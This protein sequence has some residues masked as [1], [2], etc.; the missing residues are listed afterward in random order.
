M[1]EL[2]PEAFLSRVPPQNL[3]G[4]AWAENLPLP[5]VAGIL[6][7]CRAYLGNDSGITH[8]AAAVGT[9]MLAIF[10]PTDPD[11]WGPRGENVTIIRGRAP[12]SP[13]SRE[14]RLECENRQCVLSVNADRVWDQLQGAM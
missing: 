4:G 5:T 13:C 14:K 11:V 12:C 1:K 10:G 7:K 2:L 8:I 3:F 6:S 9:P